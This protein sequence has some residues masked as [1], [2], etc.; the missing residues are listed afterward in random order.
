ML[1]PYLNLWDERFHALVAK[2][3]LSHPFKPTLYED[4]VVA[5]D[6]NDWSTSIVWL[7]KQ[8]FF[9]W[10]ITL[11]FKCFG[12]NEIALRLPSVIF[13]SFMVV[14][15]YRSGK[16]LINSKVGYYTAL[17]FATSFYLIELISGKQNV[18]HNDVISL[19]CVSGSIWAWIE[20]Y[21][22]KQKAWLIIIGLFSGCAVLCKWLIGLLVFLGWGIELIYTWWEE[23]KFSVP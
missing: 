11:S 10:L 16:L 7:H 8:P 19:C 12:V 20:Y 3:M 18:D 1:D 21:Y 5:M 23:K 15:A 6:Y 22:S 14:F 13:S 17:L 4:P 9:L 2:N